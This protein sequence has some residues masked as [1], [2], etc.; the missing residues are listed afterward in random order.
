MNVRGA[1]KLIRTDVGTVALRQALLPIVMKERPQKMRIVSRGEDGRVGVHVENMSMQEN[2]R[3]ITFM[4]DTYEVRTY[5]VT[6]ALYRR[7]HI[8]KDGHTNIVVDKW[9]DS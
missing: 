4:G 1:E 2:V 6:D 3:T 9:L 5:K 7:E 8:A